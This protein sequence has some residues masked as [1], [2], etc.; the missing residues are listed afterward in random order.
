M[1]PLLWLIKT[2]MQFLSLPV[3][4]SGHRVM[5]TTSKCLGLT[6]SQLVTEWIAA[7]TK[8][9]RIQKHRVLMATV[10]V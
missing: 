10:R 9:K 5:A 7:G 4:V 3:R 8:V 6:A 2:G 1:S